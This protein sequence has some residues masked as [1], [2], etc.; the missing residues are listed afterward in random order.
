MPDDP[1]NYPPGDFDYYLVGGQPLRDASCVEMARYAARYVSWYTMGGMRDQC[2]KWHD[3]GLRYKWPFL[4]VLNEDEY[5]TPPSDGRQ[6]TVCYDAWKKEISEV[7]PTIQLVGP[8]TA[9]GSHGAR[10]ER[11]RA[12][13]GDVLGREE[14]IGSVLRLR[15][16]AAMGTDASAVLGPDLSAMPSREASAVLS[17]QPSAAQITASRRALRMH[18]Q[19]N[20]SLFFMDPANHADGK[21][22]PFISNHVALYGPPFRAFFTGV[23]EWIQTVARPL[24]AAR[25]QLCP[26]SKLVMN[27]FIPFNNEWCEQSAGGSCD[28]TSN[29]SKKSKMRRDTLGWSAAAASFAYAFGRLSE[30]DFA[31]V[32]A[33]QL[34]GGVWPDNEPAVASLDWTTG[35]PNAKFWAV[36]LLART[37]SDRPRRVY[38]AKVVAAAAFPPDGTRA[39]GKCGE[40]GRVHGCE[41]LPHGGL[42]AT[43]HQMPSAE[44]CADAC[45]QCARCNYVSFS[46]KAAD[47]SLYAHCKW[48]ELKPDVNGYQ[49]VAVSPPSLGNEQ[50]ALFALGMEGAF[51]L[52]TLVPLHQHRRRSQDWKAREDRAKSQK[53]S[54]DRERLVLLVSKVA[55]ALNV[56]VAKGKR[57]TAWVLEGLGPDPGFNAPTARALDEQGGIFLGPYS[58]ALVFLAEARHA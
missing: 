21:P 55:H 3:S 32:G 10:G 19:L 56:R 47:C 9:G 41:L 8:E 24:D 42:N 16:R 37:L 2:G 36:Q 35:E 13:A 12:P 27:E 57:G 34:V 29:T 48:D 31:W 14:G 25:M 50:D 26:N 51:P 11:M 15:E 18:S 20:Y 39:A 7:N 53:E 1:W 46:F 28:W 6:Y 43:K 30:L 17:A 54:E 52:D 45:K 40:A 22:P 4:S 5:R 23:D 58:V 49:S 44:G 38:S 33:D